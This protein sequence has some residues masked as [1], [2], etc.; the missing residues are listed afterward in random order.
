MSFQ[1]FFDDPEE[2]TKVRETTGR[3]ALPAPTLTNL[4]LRRACTH[5]HPQAR[6]I[7]PVKEKRKEEQRAEENLKS[8]LSEIQVVEEEAAGADGDGVGD[9]EGDDVDAIEMATMMTY[10]HELAVLL[11]QSDRVLAAAVPKPSD[12]SGEPAAKRPRADDTS[13]SSSSS[14]S[15]SSSAAA[16]AAAP[17][18]VAAV[19]AA[20]TAAGVGGLRSDV[21]EV[22]RRKRQERAALLQQAADD[23]AQVTPS[24]QNHHAL[25]LDSPPKNVFTPIFF[26]IS[27]PEGGAFDPL[28]LMDWTSRSAF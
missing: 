2:E 9:D 16:A 25:S 17:A 13:N 6:G 7:D 10:Q 22:L 3:P 19:A 24:S 26:S 23:A 27:Q 20:A 28:D 1:G 4:H 21:E 11:R 12:E 18:E 14:S 5:T 15:S 8:F